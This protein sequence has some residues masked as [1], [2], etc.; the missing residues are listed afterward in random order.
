MA[1]QSSLLVVAFLA[2][3]ARA[4]DEAAPAFAK[5]HQLFDAEP[6]DAPTPTVDFGLM[7][8]CGVSHCVYPST[9]TYPCPTTF[10]SPCPSGDGDNCSTVS[11]DCYCNLATPYQCAFHPCSWYNVMLLENW[12]NQ[13]CPDTDPTVSYDFQVNSTRMF[14]PSCAL[15]CIQTQTINYGCTSES[16]NCFCS[17]QSLY[18]CTARCS[19][20]D[21]S[22]LADWLA[23]TCQISSDDATETVQDDTAGASTFK[24]GGPMPPSPPQPLHWYEIMAIV[25]LSVS[26]LL[27]LVALMN[28]EFQIYLTKQA[29][30][31]N[32]RATE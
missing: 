1:L 9:T 7:P 11:L 16:K 4:L 8:S 31:K 14:V 25:V 20:N 6:R 2:S 28:T 12:F 17:H 15:D 32:R 3:V 24:E 5:H 19:Q 21:N 22:T 18:G 29:P 27:Y 23:A 10:P 13:T 26:T 30:R